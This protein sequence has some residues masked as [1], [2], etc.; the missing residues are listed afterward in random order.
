MRE[1]SKSRKLWQKDGIEFRVLK[2][3]GIDIGG[4]DDPVVPG[5]RVFDMQDGDANDITEYVKEPYDYV[6]ASHCLEHMHDPQAALHEWWKIV[7]PGGHIFFAVPDE[8]LYEQGV[9]P[10]RFNPDHKATFTISKSKSWSPKSMNVYDM[11]RS[12][13]GGQIVQIELQDHNYDRSLMTF[14]ARKTLRQPIKF[15]LRAYEGIKRRVGP[16]IN[17]LER[18]FLQY[19]AIDQTMRPDVLAQIVCIVKKS[20]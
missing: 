18:Y 20:G 16:K 13:P 9:F 15:F 1:A 17:F 7:R 19:R 5:V 2:G 11:A 10:S 12:L 6:Y 14:G 3:A 8:D 4:G